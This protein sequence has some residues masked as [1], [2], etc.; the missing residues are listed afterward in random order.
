MCNYVLYLNI[1]KTVTVNNK[2]L[3]QLLRNLKFQFKQVFL[4]TKL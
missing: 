3:L 4:F 1:S 2:K